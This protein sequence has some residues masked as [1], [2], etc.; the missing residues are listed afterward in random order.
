M[1]FNRIVILHIDIALLNSFFYRDRV[2]C[3]PGWSGPYHVDQSF[4]ELTE[5][6]MPLTPKC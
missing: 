4:L 1:S 3:S 5:K 2:Y 6:G